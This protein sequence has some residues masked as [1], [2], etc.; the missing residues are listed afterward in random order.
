MI[1]GG[2]S[3]IASGLYATVGGGYTNIVSG[4]VATVGGG[5]SNETSANYAT[6]P[7]GYDNTA[8]GAYSF[9][10]GRRAKANHAGSFVWGDSTDADVAS[11]RD[12]Q[13]FV[14]AKGGALF[15]D[16]SGNWVNI[17]NDGAGKLINTSTGAYLSTSGAWTNT[18]DRE[19]KANF[20]AV[21]AQE[22][23]ARLAAIPIQTWNYKSQD[24][25][26]RHI[27]PVAQ[28]F[29][30]A[31]GVG[32]DDKHIST[33]DAD[34]VALAAIQELYQLL[35]EREA[36]VASLRSQVTSLRSQVASQ[37]AE[38]DDLGTRLATLEQ[39]SVTRNPQ[40]AI[41]LDWPLLGGL[42][43]AVGVVIQRR[44]AGGGR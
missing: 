18:S 27:G 16:R 29:Y 8:Q 17:W 5:F 39:Q 40:S 36:Q 26:V 22:V 6:I 37:Q 35:Q 42:I 20:A 43:V 23:L 3:N 7:G 41:S 28:D 32:E 12:N 24:P 25:S 2:K 4:T 33:V 15:D 31:F 21:D 13:F 44:R 14:R 11:Q 30:A 1:G 34:G 38:I 19:A 10:A 9:A